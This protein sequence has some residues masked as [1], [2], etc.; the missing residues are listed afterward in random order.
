MLDLHLG[1]KKTK[2][3]QKIYIWKLLHHYITLINLY[4]N[5]HSPCINLIFTNQPNLVVN[6]G[7]H[8]TLNTKCHHQISHFKLNLSIEYSPQYDWLV[9]E[10]TESVKKSFELVNRKTLLNNRIVSKQVS[11]FNETI[12]NIFSDFV[13]N[14]FI[15]FDDIDPP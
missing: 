8:S 14:K 11:I 9:K 4:Q 6:C 3:Q 10:K 12:I 15:T 1:G 7:T 13:P 2:L 5:P